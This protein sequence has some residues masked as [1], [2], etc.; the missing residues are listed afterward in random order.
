[1][2][3]GD[4][5]ANLVGFEEFLTCCLLVGLSTCALPRVHSAQGTETRNLLNSLT[6]STNLFVFKGF[7]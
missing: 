5:A 1:V 7:S 4:S 2:I 6:H 3:V